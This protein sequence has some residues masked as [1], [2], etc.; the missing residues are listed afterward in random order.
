MDDGDEFGRRYLIE[1]EIAR[2]GMGVVYSATDQLLG[3]PV[4]LKVMATWMSD[5]ATA[6]QRFLREAK[7]AA[8]VEHPNVVNIYDSG[9]V[10][11]RLYLT[12]RLVRGVDLGHVIELRGRLTPAEVADVADA[13]AAG[14]DAAHARGLVHRD[15]KPGNI[16]LDEER[17]RPVLCDFGLAKS[18]DGS[19]RLTSTGTTVGTL[20]YMAPEQVLGQEA[21]AASDVYAFGCV[22]FD[23]LTGSPPFP[24][25][26][27]HAVAMAHLNDPVPDITARVPGLGPDVQDV[28]EGCLAK[29]P[30]DRWP[31]AGEAADAL[32]DALSAAPPT[33]AP[34]ATV[35]LDGP[36]SGARRGLL[37]ACAAVVLVAGLT[38]GLVGMSAGQD[39]APEGGAPQPEES[40]PP[41]AALQA[42]LPAEVYGDSC[43]PQPAAP[44][45]LAAVKCTSVPGGGA[46]EVLVRQFEDDET[47]EAAFD[48]NYVQDDAYTK[49][50][51]SDGP[52][53]YGT[54][55]RDGERAGALACGTNSNEHATVTW[56]HDGASLQLVGVRFDRD[57]AQLYDW[58]DTARRTPLG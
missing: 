6:R 21:T 54:W 7:S 4:A 36:R 58:W 2:G 3:R 39:A 24:G 48:R 25:Q 50:S 14:L 28:L 32:R 38:G 22:L 23:C 26:S 45:Q 20:L 18:A 55:L 46:D 8:S 51:C 44:G 10:D 5:D 57:H 34:H 35:V 11:G 42:L 53:H 29:D 1:G 30:Q 17:H 56:Q 9:E 40:L 52:N 37:A 16:L 27:Q 19:T 33:D 12:M 41:Q 15:V 43:T 13:V 31:S 47:M 49:G